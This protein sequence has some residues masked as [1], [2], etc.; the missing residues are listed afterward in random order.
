M[1]T[2]CQG[3]KSW[4]KSRHAVP[5]RSRYQTA[6]TTARVSAAGRPPL[7]VPDFG[8]GRRGS[9]AAH[10]ASVRSVGYGFRVMPAVV[11]DP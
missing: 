9:N 4:G 5:V 8:F 7:R 11:P 2:V 1:Y 3:G 10:W 6:F